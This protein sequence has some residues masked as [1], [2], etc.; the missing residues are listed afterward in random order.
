MRIL[1]EH[2]EKIRKEKDFP[3][4]SATDVMALETLIQIKAH[5]LVVKDFIKFWREILESGHVTDIFMTPRWNKSFGATDEHETAKKL[6][7]KI[8]YLD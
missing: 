3:I 4:F 5:K 7:I 1:R 2:T 6:G 8:H